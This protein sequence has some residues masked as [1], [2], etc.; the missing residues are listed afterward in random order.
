ML[1]RSR[2]SPGVEVAL[3]VVVGGQHGEKGNIPLSRRIVAAFMTAP[4]VA[5]A[6]CGNMGATMIRSTSF[7]E[8]LD[9]VLNGVRRRARRWACREAPGERPAKSSML[10][11]GSRDPPDGLVGLRGLFHGR[12]DEAINNP[13]LPGRNVDNWRIGQ[14]LAEIFAGLAV[15]GPGRSQFRAGCRWKI[16]SSDSG[17]IHS[18][19]QCALE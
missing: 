9:T 15:S 2:L 6:Y 7:Q 10:I 19:G 12:G 8:F 16:L 4:V 11:R 14:E 13:A 5:E 18:V 17:S 1:Q 3:V